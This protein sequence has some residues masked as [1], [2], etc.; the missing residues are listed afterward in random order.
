MDEILFKRLMFAGEEE[1]IEEL[2]K[3]GYFTRI[4]GVVCRTQKF[5]EETG[6]FI[7]A[8]KETLFEAVKKIGSAEDME[9]VME[10][11]GLKD[12]IT[13][14]FLAEELVE[15]GR[16]VKDKVKNVVVKK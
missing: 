8:R 15:D 2:I 14:I 3:M 12:F 13:F 11:A 5:V 4:D 16:L 6:S 10:M 9:K 7:D 1:D